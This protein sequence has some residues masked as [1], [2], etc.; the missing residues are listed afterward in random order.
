MKCIAFIKY[1]MVYV[2]IFYKLDN[3]IQV[4]CYY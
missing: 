3:E 2:H 1:Y 4:N